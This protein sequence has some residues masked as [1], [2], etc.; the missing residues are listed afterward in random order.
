VVAAPEQ[1]AASQALTAGTP[2][3]KH[4]NVLRAAAQVREAWIASRRATLPA[5]V[6]GYVARR[7]V[8]VG[9]RVQPGAP[10]MSVVPLDQVWV[11]ANFR[12]VELRDMRIGQPARITSDVYGGKVVYTGRIAGL[13]V[14]TGSTFALLP[15]QNATGNWIKVVQR[16]P[17]RIAL[18][19]AGLDA[20]PLRVGLSMHVRVDIRDLSGPAL[21]GEPRQ[22][23]VATTRVFEAQDDGA[24]ARIDRIVA[25]N[26]APAA[27]PRTRR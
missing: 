18:D 8:Q 3:E 5:P 2:V 23:A 12:E 11:E 19:P 10:L 14:G 26:L 17:V 16:V 22:A 13:G 15:A 9:Q 7:N 27:G 21:A 24:Q 25:A 1:L 20:H 4:P 6:S